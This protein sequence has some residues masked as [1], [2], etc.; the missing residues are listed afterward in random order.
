MFY[1]SRDTNDLWLPIYF[2][3][4]ISISVSV[5]FN[6]KQEG[7][8][9]LWYCKITLMVCVFFKFARRNGNIEKTSHL[10]KMK[11]LHANFH[12]TQ[13]SIMPEYSC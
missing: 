8:F 5:V 9:V 4:I 7:I 6:E 11:L 13:L 10:S 3:T 1:L 12:L 2:I